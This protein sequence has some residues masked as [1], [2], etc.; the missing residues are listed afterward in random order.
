VDGWTFRDKIIVDAT[1]R[2]NY[3]RASI[4]WVCGSALHGRAGAGGSPPGAA[5]PFLLQLCAYPLYH[6]ACM[7]ATPM[8]RASI[9]LSVAS[10]ALTHGFLPQR[11]YTRPQLLTRT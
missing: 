2:L 4:A 6:R 3:S 11:F 5:H 7:R 10:L 8:K 1:D 9:P